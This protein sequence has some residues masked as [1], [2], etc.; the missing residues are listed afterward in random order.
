MS[1]GEVSI[2][3]VSIAD[4]QTFPDGCPKDCVLTTSFYHFAVAFE[5]IQN[6][7][8][9]TPPKDPNEQPLI[10][11][12]NVPNPTPSSDNSIQPLRHKVEEP[13]T[14]IKTVSEYND[15]FE[16]LPFRDNIFV[17]PDSPNDALNNHLL[18]LIYS[19]LQPTPTS[20]HGGAGN[21][22]GEP[23]KIKGIDHSPISYNFL[24]ET[25]VTQENLDSKT[26]EPKEKP[27]LPKDE[28]KANEEKPPPYHHHQWPMY[29]PPPYYWY[30][31]YHYGYHHHYGTQDGQ[32]NH[33]TSHPTLYPK[34]HNGQYH[35]AYRPSPPY[36]GKPLFMA[37]HPLPAEYITDVTNNDV[38]CG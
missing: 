31:Q 30:H 1:Y 4:G 5:G 36:F 34:P 37:G 13:F 15:D 35:H 27:Q 18:Q 29:P 20:D 14:P 19:P 17:G 21:E 11:P 9:V 3:V 7:A 16:P 10:T 12:S 33:R 23:K 26:T 2:A 25:S 6:D 32:S 22:T 24:S 38:I 28:A 8:L